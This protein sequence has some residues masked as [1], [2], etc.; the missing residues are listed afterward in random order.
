MKKQGITQ[1]KMFKK[2]LECVLTDAEVLEYS[3][4]LAK[5]N[6]DLSDVEDRK[7][8]VVA[9]Y[10]AEAKSLEA[11]IN[12]LAR[13]VASGKEHR[14]VECIYEFDWDKAVKHIIRRDTYEIIKTEVIDEFD[15]Q[16]GLI[17]ENPEI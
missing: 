12:V 16:Q 1:G 8:D 7:K 15:R 4:S 11:N 13:K 10:T 3:R 14:S 5:A 6:Q 2:E 9:G 17:E